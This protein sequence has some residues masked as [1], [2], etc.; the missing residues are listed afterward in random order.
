MHV[1]GVD[2]FR[3]G[4]VRWACR[5]GLCRYRAISLPPL[6]RVECTV[7]WLRLRGPGASRGCDATQGQPPRTTN[8]CRTCSQ[9]WTAFAACRTYPAPSASPGSASAGASPICSRCGRKNSPPARTSMVWTWTC[10]G[11]TALTRSASLRTSIAHSPASSATWTRTPRLRTWTKLETVLR[12]K[13]KP[14][15]FHRYP[16]GQHAFNDPYN[17]GAVRPGDIRRLM[18]RNS[19]RFF[20]AALKARKP[21]A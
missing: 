6:R 21:V 15:T 8:Y 13:G 11:A 1:F 14:F 10:P 16:S 7:D 19:S 12:A 17:P 3:A 5:G 2:R 4:E 9:G 20:D 18:G